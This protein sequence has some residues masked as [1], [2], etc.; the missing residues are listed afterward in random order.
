LQLIVEIKLF[1][2]ILGEICTLAAFL[3]KK[4]KASICNVKNL[5]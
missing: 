1:L 3:N 5:S 2:S 4:T